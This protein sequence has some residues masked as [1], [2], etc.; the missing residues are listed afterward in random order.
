MAS[1]NFFSKANK[2]IQSV[3]INGYDK[4][5][6]SHISRKENRTTH[7]FFLQ[8]T[9][10]LCEFHLNKQYLFKQAHAYLCKSTG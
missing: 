1:I 3:A 8:H 5:I 6:N 4:V 2:R 7:E 10:G 9:N